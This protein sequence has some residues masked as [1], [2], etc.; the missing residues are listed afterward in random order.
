MDKLAE[1][2]KAKEVV[3]KTWQQKFYGPDLQKEVLIAYLMGVGWSFDEACDA[4]FDGKL[5]TI[6]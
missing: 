2:N 6:H 3:F 1:L 4:A 5:S